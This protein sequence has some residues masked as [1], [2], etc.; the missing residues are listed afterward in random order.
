MSERPSIEAVYA[1]L[2]VG[3]AKLP[4]IARRTLGIPHIAI[5]GAFCRGL[6]DHSE[7]IAGAE[8]LPESLSRNPLGPDVHPIS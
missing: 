7:L 8:P 5:S 3:F 6:T 4:Q 2:T 1:E